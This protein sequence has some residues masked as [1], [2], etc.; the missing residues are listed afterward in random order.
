M[1]IIRVYICQV[2]KHSLNPYLFLKGYQPSPLVCFCNLQIRVS[3]PPIYA[4]VEEEITRRKRSVPSRRGRRK[5][6]PR[7]MAD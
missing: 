2:F 5:R 1:I 7:Q 6:K 4:C 3:Y